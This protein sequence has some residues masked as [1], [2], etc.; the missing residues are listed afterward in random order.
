MSY[1]FLWFF[2]FRSLRKQRVF[3][4]FFIQISQRLHRPCSVAGTIL[5]VLGILTQ[6]A[7]AFATCWGQKRL[8][9][10]VGEGYSKDS[11]IRSL[12]RGPRTLGSLLG[13]MLMLPV[14]WLH[15]GPE[16][17][18]MVS[19][20]D[21]QKPQVI[22]TCVKRDRLSS[23]CSGS[24]RVLIGQD[25]AWREPRG[26]SFGASLSPG[27]GGEGVDAG[28]IA[29]WPDTPTPWFLLF[30]CLLLSAAPESGFCTL[31]GTGSRGRALWLSDSGSVKGGPRWFAVTS[32]LPHPE[33]PP[34]PK[35][36][37][38]QEGL[39][40]PFLWCLWEASLPVPATH[41][42]SSPSLA[43]EPAPPHHHHK[44]KEQYSSKWVFIIFMWWVNKLS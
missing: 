38:L 21:K 34:C 32:Q 25:L 44:Y 7:S 14:C 41:H 5:K 11:D 24:N 1:G 18:Q 37:P 28:A 6:I 16:S 8:F 9:L 26:W 2:K 17:G 42:F 35:C 36:R 19:G 4:T 40:H 22:L 20:W 12:V 29:L 31:R 33:R 43:L 15:S 3:E 13:S 23:P 27:E 39:H 10:R 30:Y